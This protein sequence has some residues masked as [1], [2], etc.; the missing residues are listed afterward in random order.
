MAPSTVLPSTVIDYANRS[1]HHFQIPTAKESTYT[2]KFS[3]IV[4]ASK[5]V[6]TRRVEPAD[7]EVSVEEN[8]EFKLP[9]RRSLFIIIGGNALFQFSFF[10]I[11][12]SASV[13]AE[14]LGGSETFSGLIIGIP[15]A[16]SGI[17][18]IFVTRSD[19]GRYKQPLNLAYASMVL[20]NV[21]Y[22][23]AYR[24]NFLYMILIGR[25]VSGFGYIAF[26]YSKRYCSDPRIVGVRRR[27][28]LAGWLVIGQGFGFSAGPFIGGLLYKIG[29]PNKIFNGVTSPGWVVAGFWILFW[30]LSTLIFE[31]VPARSEDPPIELQ[32]RNETQSITTPETQSLQTQIETP[33]QWGVIAC[34]C[35]YSMTCFFI[36]GGW[37]SNIPIYTAGAFGY[38]P[39]NAGN[40]I[41]LGGISSFPFLLI[42]VRYAKRLQDRTILAAGSTLG[43]IGLLIMLAT[44]HTQ[45]VTFGS[46]FVCWFLIALG[47]NLASTCTL[48]LLSKQLPD[49]WNRKVSMAIQ[50][51]N[52][53]GRV[54]GAILGGAGV[55]IGMMNYIGIQ[56]AVVGIGGVMYLTL[57]RQLKA[58]TG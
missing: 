47:F 45:K 3:E 9:S 49:T 56:I 14:L 53:A 33:H 15:T 35:Y 24:A 46:L 36:L 31:D 44:L 32:T 48:S 17:A 51:S 1:A 8:P 12:S 18:L 40:F 4:G 5:H 23:L 22:G 41:A 43:L 38:S 2:S 7:E 20:G 37:E 21:L 55:Q 57:W 10:V 25:I 54:T 50:Y 42:N 30:A 28:T 58:K 29:F 19:G 27:T 16:F 6:F 39:F 13:Y 52:Y 11:I 26:M 34:M